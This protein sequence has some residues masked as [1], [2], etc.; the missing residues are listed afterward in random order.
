VSGRNHYY[1]ALYRGKAALRKRVNG[2]HS[3][4]KE[5]PFTIT[6][7]PNDCASKPSARLCGSTSTTHWWPK[8]RTRSCPP[9][10]TGPSHLHVYLVQVLA[11]A[12]ASA[13]HFCS[14]CDRRDCVEPA[15]YRW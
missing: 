10:A 5:V 6:A 7:F 3:T 4:I 12:L 14:A 13:Q 9:G 8:G 1:V 11:V 2:V 15:G